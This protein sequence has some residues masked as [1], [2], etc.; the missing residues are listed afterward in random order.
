M[1]GRGRKDRDEGD[2]PKVYKGRL[3]GVHG[4]A[5]FT[6]QQLHA[7]ADDY[8]EQAKAEDSPDDPKWCLRRASRLR[9][10]AKQKEKA[11]EHKRQQ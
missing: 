4:M 8:E 6:A 7:M 9:A 5:T 3:D 11:L 1:R 2:M 10:L